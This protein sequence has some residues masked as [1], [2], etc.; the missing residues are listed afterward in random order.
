RLA[1]NTKDHLTIR[2]ILKKHEVKLVSVSQ[3]MVEDSA[4]GQMIDT[5]L[6]SV[7]QFQSDL[8]A[9]KSLKGMEQK[10][11]TGGWP[12]MA[13]LGYRNVWKDPEGKTRV[14][15]LDPDRAPFIEEA[16]RLY[17]SGKYSLAGLGD[18]LY[19][20]GL[21]SRRGKKLAT[22]RLAKMLQN[23]FYTGHVL[24][25]GI[26]AQGAHP[27]LVSP[28]LFR[29]VSLL[30]SEK[31]GLASRKRKH[32]FLLSGFLRC[33]R[34]GRQLIGEYHPRKR[35]GYYRCHTRGGC[36][37]CVEFGTITDQV[38][39]K[40][41]SVVLSERFSSALIR[42]LR[43]MHEK[44]R[45]QIQRKQ[46]LLL[47][48]KEGLEARRATAEKK[49]LEGVLPSESFARI[50]GEITHDL[51]AVHDE[52]RSVTLDRCGH[53]EFLEEV[54]KLSRDLPGAYDR[55]SE[56]LKRLYLGFFWEEFRIRDVGI[57]EAKPT[58]LFASLLESQAIW[59]RESRGPAG[60]GENT[61]KK[62]GKGLGR[63]CDDPCPWRAAIRP[64]LSILENDVV[65]QK[66]KE[67]WR[68]I[69]ARR[70]AETPPPHSPCL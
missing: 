10:A 20:Q 70:E 6:A 50:N 23:P 28:A 44:Y 37:P 60:A 58:P 29:T 31:A 35:R 57:A 68:L 18:H 13:P 33:V 22:S 53:S 4:E 25:R 7:N 26:E 16:F 21:R 41:R 2:A 64:I 14:V 38:R 63:T 42:R 11:R 43:Q 67:Q 52:I 5:I 47:N 55:A 9:R 30:L 8:T 62:P 15:E 17:A 24:W 3:P 51:L 34:C 40:V 45:G 46:K 1:R 27:P 59:M 36:S 49:L 19:G 65:M 56:D 32:R 54:V 66:A 69:Q 48:K 61:T 12:N 39:V